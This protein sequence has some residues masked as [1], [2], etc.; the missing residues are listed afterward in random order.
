MKSALT[1]KYTRFEI[2]FFLCYFLLFSLLSDVEFNLREPGGEVAGVFTTIPYRM[3]SGL[4]NL[5]PYLV[6]YKL[7]LQPFLLKKRYLLFTIALTLF[8]VLFNIYTPV[9]NWIT[10]FFMFKQVELKS[11]QGIDFSKI[12]RVNYSIMY[13]LRELL[14]VTAL[15]YF[16]RSARQDQTL[17]E[18]KEQQLSAELNY[19]KVQLQPHFYFNTLNNI[20]SLTLQGSEKAPLLISK[21]ADMMRY[22][23]YES[24][25]SR[26]PLER[27]VEFLRNYVEVEV[28]RFPPDIEITFESQGISS[29]AMIEPL[30]LLPFIENPFKHGLNET[31]STGSFVQIIISQVEQELSVQIRNSKRPSV[32][33]QPGIGQANATKRLAMLYPGKHAIDIYEDETTYEVCLMLILKV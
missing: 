11:A 32:D 21:H 23:L 10:D 9:T 26:A 4:L 17:Q 29:K 27:E 2:I 16:I 6:Y 7:I 28:M 13:I 5:L 25:Q 19:L 24:S 18:L 33:M 3:V 30:L 15:G 31:L 22:I 8:L 20:Y 12:V 1:D 14:V